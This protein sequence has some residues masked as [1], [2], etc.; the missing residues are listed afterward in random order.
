MITFFFVFVIIFQPNRYELKECRVELT[1]LNLPRSADG[2]YDIGN[3]SPIDVN[4]EFDIQIKEESEDDCSII[5]QVNVLPYHVK[6]VENMT[7]PLMF[8]SKKQH[9]IFLKLESF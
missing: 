7:K 8:W 1:R 6:L 3:L 9:L 4:V 5:E 2:S